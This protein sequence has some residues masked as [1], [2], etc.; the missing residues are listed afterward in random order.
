MTNI[1][2]IESDYNCEYGFFWIQIEY[3]Q[4]LYWP[5][6]CLNQRN[7]ENGYKKEINI[8]DCGYDWGSCGD[9]TSLIPEEIAEK[10]FKLMISQAR[11][12]GI[13]TIK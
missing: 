1:K 4:K 11:K 3:K 6:C 8:D 10:A 13:R 12:E 5:Q 9:Y 2:I 7:D